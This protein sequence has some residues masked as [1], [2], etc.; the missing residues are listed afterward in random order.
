MLVRHALK[1]LRRKFTKLPSVVSGEL[2]HM[3]EAPAV[4]D[5]GDCGFRSGGP[6]LTPDSDEA[7]RLEILFG[8]DTKP[9]PESASQGSFGN[10]RFV[11]QV[12]DRVHFM[13]PFSGQANGHFNQPLLAALAGLAIG[14]DSGSKTPSK[15]VAR[16]LFDGFRKAPAID[17]QCQ[18]GS[19]Q[20]LEITDD[21]GSA[22][23]DLQAPQG[24]FWE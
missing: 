12:L 5:V 20:I 18:A 16:V 24:T 19:H 6:E 13:R 11:A 10:T 2:P 17:E 8:R 1:R 21:P 22:G 15:E 4:G 3:P 9:F 23:R 14:S 7:L